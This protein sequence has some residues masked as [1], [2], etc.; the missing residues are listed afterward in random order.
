[1]I[2]TKTLRSTTKMVLA[3]TQ[4]R[5]QPILRVVERGSERYCPCCESSLRRFKTYGV[6]PRPNAM[7]GVCGSLERD[8]LVYMF[9]RRET[10]LEDGAPKKVLHIAPE[11]LF[12]RLFREAANTDYVSADLMDVSAMVRMDITDIQYPENSFDVIYC[13]HVLEHVPDDRLAMREF[14]R[15]LKPGRWAILQVPI[16]A[17]KTFE[18]PSVT[19]PKERERLFG[20]YDHVRRYG[21][22]YVDRL[23][24]AGFSVQVV[25]FVSKLDPHEAA[26]NGL[27]PDDRIYFCRKE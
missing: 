8:R 12:T 5:F 7:C 18:D 11:P 19:D 13:S 2:G 20:Q 6:V 16:T 26:R 22:D 15:V 10:D 9:V 25:D 1:M 27:R 24:E 21:P 4:E 14:Y 23:T 3:R 17:E